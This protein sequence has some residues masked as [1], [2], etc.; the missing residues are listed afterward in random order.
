M[1]YGQLIDMIAFH[2]KEFNVRY[3]WSEEYEYQQIY[4]SLPNSDKE[5]LVDVRN[6]GL[7]KTDSPEFKA[8]M[9]AIISNLNRISKG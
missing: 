2:F 9:D 1:R 3:A 4:L 5:M 7:V 6:I 8:F